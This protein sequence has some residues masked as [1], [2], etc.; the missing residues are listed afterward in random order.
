MANGAAWQSVRKSEAREHSRAEAYRRLADIRGHAIGEILS[1]R[2][3][4]VG[5]KIALE[6]VT[7]RLRVLGEPGY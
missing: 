7:R 3:M 5:T 1:G 4:S 2:A 6:C